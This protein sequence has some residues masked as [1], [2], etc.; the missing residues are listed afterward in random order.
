MPETLL[1]TSIEELC[2]KFATDVIIRMATG[3]SAELEPTTDDVVPIT[4]GEMCK[5]ITTDAILD[6]A[7]ENACIEIVTSPNGAHGG[8]GLDEVALSKFATIE[9]YSLCSAAI[10]EAW[11]IEVNF[12]LEHPLTFADAVEHLK[13]LIGATHDICILEV[14]DDRPHQLDGFTC[15]ITTEVDIVIDD[16]THAVCLVE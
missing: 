16:G 14:L 15:M 7:V 2:S 5:V 3:I 9:L 12:L 8:D 10:D 4:L 13:V 6:E 11:A 1:S